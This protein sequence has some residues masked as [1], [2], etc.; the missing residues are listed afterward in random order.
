MVTAFKDMAVEAQVLI[1]VTSE[2]FIHM[3][4]QCRKCIIEHRRH[5][6]LGVC[7][8]ASTP[9]SVSHHYQRSGFPYL[10]SPL[11][12]RSL[13]KTLEL[14]VSHIALLVSLCDPPIEY[15]FGSLCTSETTI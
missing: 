13:S 3:M 12:S 10:F 7:F 8:G 14:G 11:A 9:M 5:T 4:L 2:S 15:E 6:S 1:E